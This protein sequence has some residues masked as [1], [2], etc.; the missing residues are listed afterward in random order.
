MLGMVIGIS[1]FF[2]HRTLINLAEAQRQGL[3]LVNLLP[4]LLLVVA[5]AWWLRRPAS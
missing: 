2:A 1:F 4:P 3:V 5:S